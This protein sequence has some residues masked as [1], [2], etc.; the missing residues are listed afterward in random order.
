M[1]QL[2]ILDGFHIWCPNDSI[3]KALKDG[4]VMKSQLETGV[5]SKR[6]RKRHLVQIIDNRKRAGDRTQH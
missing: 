4:K 6:K 3:W 1:I 5:K 2:E